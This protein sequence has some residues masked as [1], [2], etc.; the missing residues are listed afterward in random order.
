MANKENHAFEYGHHNQSSDI[1]HSLF[2]GRNILPYDVCKVIMRKSSQ[3]G[4][5]GQFY[6][7]FFLLLANWVLFLFFKKS[8]ALGE[9]W[10]IASIACPASISPC[11]SVA[12]AAF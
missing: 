1:C 7:F 4:Q 11:F 10:L 6:Y 2:A 12:T 8:D 3:Q 5:S 9:A